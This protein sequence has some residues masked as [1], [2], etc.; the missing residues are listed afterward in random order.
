MGKYEHNFMPVGL[1]TQLGD[2]LQVRI[3]ESQVE[4]A[5]NTMTGGKTVL[6][7]AMAC[8]RKPTLVPTDNYLDYLHR[9]CNN[10]LRYSE[11]R[12]ILRTEHLS[13]FSEED[14]LNIMGVYRK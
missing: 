2:D 14:C 12:A 9:Y 8:L 5:L 3:I 11:P 7:F 1:L 10:L 4:E 13:E 6:K